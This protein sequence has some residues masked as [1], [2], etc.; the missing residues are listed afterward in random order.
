[1]KIEKRWVIKESIIGE[2][3]E[4]FF[5]G[6][7]EN[8]EMNKQ[9]AVFEKL[10]S[11]TRL[12]KLARDANKAIDRM[13]EIGYEGRPEPEYIEFAEVPDKP[14]PENAE[15]SVITDVVGWNVV[16]HF[17]AVK[18]LRRYGADGTWEYAYIDRSGDLRWLGSDELNAWYTYSDERTAAGADRIK[19]RRAANV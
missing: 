19:A 1:M 12:Y 16:D 18:Y 15:P 9:S 11:S 2:D 13:R 4:F 3:G 5:A 7:A 14:K 8:P 10:S 17:G 6:M